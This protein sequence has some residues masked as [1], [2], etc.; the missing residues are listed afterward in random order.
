MKNKLVFLTKMSLSKKIKTKW[1]LIANLIFAIITIGLI[2]IDSIIK[3]F[4]GDFNEE[5]TIMIIDKANCFEAF[6]NNYESYAKYVKDYDEVVI[7][8]Y[9]GTQKEAEKQ[10]KEDNNNILLV[11]NNDE[12]NFI[13]A[14]LISW[15]GIGTVTNTLINTTLTS[16]RSEKALKTY[17]IEKEVYDS[18][19]VPIQAKTKILNDENKDS[20]LTMASI[21]QIITLP[22][23]ML[24]VFLVQ[25][26]GAE[27]NEEKTTKS[28]EIII[29]NVSPKTHFISKIISSNLFVLIQ[30]ALLIIFVLIGIAIRYFLCGGSLVGQLDREITDVVNNLNLSGVTST[31]SYMLPIILVM[32]VLTFI[33]YSLLGGILASMTTNLEDYQQLQTPIVIISL[34]GYYLSMIA[35]VFKG[36]VFLKIMSYIPL[37]SSMLSPTLYV[38]GEI[39]LFDLLGSI[40][41]LILFI[42]LLFKY[43]MRIYKVGILNYS[44]T[45]LWKKMFK[46]VKEK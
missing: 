27:V 13:K 16:I 19:N 2:N 6:S 8:K 21:M 5:Q 28:M 43:G 40:V 4:G 1:F 36:S 22:I 34:I 45:G 44:Q 30:G 29:S 3:A 25:M 7:K 14:E 35:S 32:L 31:I 12:E 42:Y 39:T 41:L 20:S 23:F 9:D 26:I 10:I 11:I 38:M 33:A 46:A 17:G 15:D 24:I 37:L 18:I